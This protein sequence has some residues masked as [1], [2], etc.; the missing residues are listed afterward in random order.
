[1]SQKVREDNDW[2]GDIQYVPIEGTESIDN[3]RLGGYHPLQIG[4]RFGSHNRY[5]VVHKLGFG[6]HSTTWLARDEFQGRLVAL[7]IAIA[8]DTG[9]SQ[10]IHIL[11]RLRESLCDTAERKHFPF[12]TILDSFTHNGPNGTHECLVTEPGM[13]S[14]AKSKSASKGV[15]YFDLGVARSITAQLIRA[16]VLLHSQGIV[17]GGK[18]NPSLG[19]ANQNFLEPNTDSRPRERYPPR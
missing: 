2:T 13:C 12:P 3:Y 6:G 4:D 10:E 19:Y 11:Q 17:H 15:W 9:S 18:S 14:L 16:T 7:K 5:Q 1:M 8:S